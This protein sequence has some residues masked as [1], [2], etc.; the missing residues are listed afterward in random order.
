MLTARTVPG[1]LAD[2][3]L[4]PAELQERLV[5]GGPF[6]RARLLA[7]A[8]GPSI[9]P[10]LGWD[11]IVISPEERSRLLDVVH[12]A[13]A[14]HTRVGVPPVI[15]TDAV[16]RPHLR[17]LI[18]LEFPNL[19]VPAKGEVKVR[20]QELGPPRVRQG[21]VGFS[22]CKPAPGRTARGKPAPAVS[23][24]QET[25]RRRQPAV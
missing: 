5:P 1:T 22:G 23:I 3:A 11:K 13:L 9:G 12:A 7:P 18:E 21:R 14:A 6:L 24:R 25:P 19:P 8:A 2:L 4:E 10:A 16:T 17:D 20:V 15:L